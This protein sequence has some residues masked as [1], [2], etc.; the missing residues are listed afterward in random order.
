MRQ[1]LQTGRAVGRTTGGMSVRRPCG[2][3]TWAATPAGTS[4]IGFRPSYLVGQ[5]PPVGSCCGSGQ[6][7]NAVAVLVR[8]FVATLVVM[9]TAV[10]GTWVVVPLGA[11][12]VTFTARD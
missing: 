3:Q 2:T 12:A 11:A 5:A 6:P 1:L 9:L 4:V 7:V 8:N 10:L